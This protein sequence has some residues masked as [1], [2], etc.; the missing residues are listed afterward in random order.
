MRS[1]SDPPIPR[2][3]PG[4]KT[5]RIAG[6][7]EDLHAPFR[8]A[9]LD[10]ARHADGEVVETVVIE[11]AGGEGGAEELILG[12]GI[13]PRGLRQSEPAARRREARTRGA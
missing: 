8:H 11:V 2:T 13:R 1:S 5:V 3:R 7:E 4:P 6:A 9:T 10:V 12:R